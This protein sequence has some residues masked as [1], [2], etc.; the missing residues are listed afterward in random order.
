MPLYFDSLLALEGNC[1]STDG[2]K[3]ELT[4]VSSK[5]YTVTGHFEYNGQSYSETFDIFWI[6]PNQSFFGA[7]KNDLGRFAFQCV[8]NE[9]NTWSMRKTYTNMQSKTIPQKKKK[10]TVGYWKKHEFDRAFQSM[11]DQG[12]RQRKTPHHFT[13]TMDADSKQCVQKK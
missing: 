13:L 10:R 5:Q 11:M 1:F 9:N 6:E 12:P 8:R 3:L 4:S 2:Y 7:G